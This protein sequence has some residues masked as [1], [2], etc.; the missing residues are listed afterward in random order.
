MEI[1]AEPFSYQFPKHVGLWLILTALVMAR[2]PTLWLAGEFVAEDAWVFF[3]EAFNTTWLSSLLYPYAGYFHLLPR[4][5]AELLSI[6]PL[7]YQPFLYALVGIGTNGVI[8]SLFYLPHFRH[9][10]ASDTARAAICVT[11][12]L[13]HNSENMGFIMGQ[14]WYMAFLLPMLLVMRSPVGKSGRLGT[15]GASIICTWSTPSNLALIPFLLISTLKDKD[16]AKRKWSAFTLINLGVVTG[17]ILLLRI[18]DSERTGEFIWSQIPAALDRLI[19]RGWLGTG[20]I[21]QPIST[22]IASVQPLLLDIFGALVLIAVSALLY[23]YKRTEIGNS[24][25]IL[26]GASLLMIGLSMTRSIYLTDLAQIDLP[27]HVRY[28]TTP[29]LSITLMILVI[30]YDRL[31]QKP[32]IWFYGIW[33]AYCAILVSGL[34]FLNHWA[35]EPKLFFFR[36]YVQAIE[37]FETNYLKTDQTAQ[38]YVPSDVPYWGPVLKSGTIIA[39]DLDQNENHT[40]VTQNGSNF[41]RWLISTR[42]KSETNTLINKQLGYLRFDGLA[43][44]R[45][46]FRDTE[47]RLLFTSELMYPKIWR[48]SGFNFELLDA[49]NEDAE[50]IIP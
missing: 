49:G 28:L 14:H 1:K 30:I 11:L 5:Y 22:F 2:I 46:W 16:P 33:A 38:L 39:Q 42:Q 17:F 24:G 8:F 27:R 35:R 26:L 12:A 40:S 44:G 43:E 25:L 6:F 47:D 48:M 41:S 9:L 50:P 34:P 29:S 4:I 13:V 45:A 18:R 3:A 20:V 7:T 19:L 23:K 36:D 32:L 10:L 21:G 15:M 37:A 31:K